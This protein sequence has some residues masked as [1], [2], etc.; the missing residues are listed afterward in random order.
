MALVKFAAGQFFDNFMSLPA[1]ARGT[2]NQGRY[3]AKPTEPNSYFDIIIQSEK[4][5]LPVQVNNLADVIFQPPADRDEESVIILSHCNHRY[6]SISL[7]RL[8][9]VVLELYKQYRSKGI[10]RGDTVLVSCLG[11]DN[12]LFTALQFLALTSYG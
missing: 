3:T 1:V 5:I 6:I 12:E 7:E 4:H 11:G 2:F 8:R 9:F 10:N